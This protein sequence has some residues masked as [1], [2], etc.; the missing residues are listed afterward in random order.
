MAESIGFTPTYM[1]AAFKSE[2]GH[3]VLEYIMQYRVETAKRK[4]AEMPDCTIEEI[5]RQ[6]GYD[7]MRTFIRIFRKYEGV[8]P[9]QYRNSNT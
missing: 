5:S 7:N 2:T 9:L 8:T 1:S 3:G 4:I 6:V